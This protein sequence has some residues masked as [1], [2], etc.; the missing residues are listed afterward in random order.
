MSSTPP[1][2]GASRPPSRRTVLAGAAWS[3]PAIV[4]VTASPAAAASHQLVLTFERTSYAGPI[5]E[6]IDEVVATATMDGTPQAGVAVT[7]TLSDGYTFAGGA[8]TA[9]GTSDGNGRFAVPTIDV[10]NSGKSGTAAATASGATAGTTTLRSAYAL[11]LS[12]ANGALSMP[13]VF[14]DIPSTATPVGGYGLFVDGTDLWYVDRIIASGVSGVR[15]NRSDTREYWSYFANGVATS[16]VGSNG[17][18]IATETFSRVPATA[19]VGGSYGVFLDRNARQLWYRNTVWENSVSAVTAYTCFSNGARFD[20]A[21]YAV[22]PPGGNTVFTL[23]RWKNG[24]GTGTFDNTTAPRDSVFE[25]VPNLLSS[26]NG[27]RL[28]WSDSTIAHNVTGV[29]GSLIVDWTE[30]ISSYIE[31]GVATSRHSADTVWTFPAV[32][33]SAKAV[34]SWATFL[35]GNDLWFNNAVAKTNVVSAVGDSFTSS[36]D[37]HISVIKKGC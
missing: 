28:D 13:A 22:Q 23:Q 3:V 29:S 24:T 35:D 4:A 34:G 12:T 25:R 31:S 32:P 2:N 6:T 20:Y 33:A 36:G 19:E 26:G 15:A 10:P 27:A 9:T 5:C 14:P 17:T 1:L 16:S 21:C 8:T 18:V 11:F 30:A 37:S 7:V